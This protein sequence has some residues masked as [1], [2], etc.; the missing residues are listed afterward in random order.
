M[1]E[2]ATV[3]KKTPVPEIQPAPGRAMAPLR[4]QDWEHS[5]SAECPSSPGG[6][7]GT[8]PEKEPESSAGP[9]SRDGGLPPVTLQVR[10]A[11]CLPVLPASLEASPSCWHLWRPPCLLSSHLLSSWHLWL[12]AFLLSSPFQVGSSCVS[13]PCLLC[14]PQDRGLGWDLTWHPHHTLIPGPDS[15]KASDASGRPPPPH[16]PPSS[17]EAL[18][19]GLALGLWL[20]PHS[21][22]S[23]QVQR[24]GLL[25]LPR[26]C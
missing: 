17:L 8:G 22:G 13:P 2:K 23:T 7:R 15:R 3:F 16:P 25:P 24:T 21:R 26:S 18:S 9:L 19:T 14:C 5:A 4:P 12:P 20:H 11:P 1:S 6:Q 10:S